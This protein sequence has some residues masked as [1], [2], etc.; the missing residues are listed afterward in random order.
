ME[1]KTLASLCFFLIVVFASQEMMVET[2]AKICEVLSG[3]YKGP[4]FAGCDV[5]C[6]EQDHLLGGDCKGLK[7]W[8][9][10]NC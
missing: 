6:T 2:E 5:T 8:C 1:K 10:K 7:C 3:K 9:R 4:C